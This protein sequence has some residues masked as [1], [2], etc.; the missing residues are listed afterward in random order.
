MT[1]QQL[2]WLKKCEQIAERHQI[3]KATILQFE[4]FLI[5]KGELDE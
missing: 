5:K 1:I 4:D 3:S 2:D